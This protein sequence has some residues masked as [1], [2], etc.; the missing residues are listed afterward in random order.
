LRLASDAAETLD[1]VVRA[2]AWMTDPAKHHGTSADETARK[3]L[4]AAEAGRIDFEG[5][6]AA[7]GTF[8]SRRQAGI[9]AKAQHKLRCEPV[10]LPLPRTGARAVRVASEAALL[11]LGRE[12]GNCLAEPGRHNHH[13]RDFRS[14]EAEFWRIDDAKGRLLLVIRSCTAFDAV[15]EVAG[16]RNDCPTLLARAAVVEFMAIRG[17]KPRT[18]ERTAVCGFIVEAIAAGTLLCR[19]A[20]IAGSPWTL[21]IAPLAVAGLAKNSEARWMLTMSGWHETSTNWVERDCLQGPMDC[22]D[23]FHGLGSAAD[24]IARFH[25]RAACRADAGL[26]RVL[27]A[28]F[29]PAPDWMRDDWFG[30][31]AA[32][33]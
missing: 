4:R 8:Q 3:T 29:A 5:L 28:A 23:D 6:I 25:L 20:N 13:R 31:V 26:S 18:L 30:P 7:C 27:H 11:A 16:P 24:A 12:A 19:D 21:E 32:T 10:D 14:G 22:G 15:E 17:L 33:Q 9:R 2:L 1:R